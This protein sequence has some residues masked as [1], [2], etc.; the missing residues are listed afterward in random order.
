MTDAAAGASGALFGGLKNNAFL[1]SCPQPGS[2]K[3]RPQ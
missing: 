1:K 2:A 3:Q